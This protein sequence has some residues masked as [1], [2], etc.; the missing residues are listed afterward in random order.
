M[1]NR[2]FCYFQSKLRCSFPIACPRDSYCVRTTQSIPVPNN[3]PQDQYNEDFMVKKETSAMTDETMPD[4]TMSDQ[5]VLSISV[6]AQRIVYR[7]IDGK[8]IGEIL[9]R[10]VAALNDSDS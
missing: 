10:L 8:D 4:K 5:M 9:I 7:I 3:H 2:Q 6:N 1:S